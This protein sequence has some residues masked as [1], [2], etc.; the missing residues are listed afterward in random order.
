[1]TE[2]LKYNLNCYLRRDKKKYTLFWILPIFS[3]FLLLLCSFK[4]MAY[5]V[6][7]TN[8]E[9]LCEENCN[10]S[11]YYPYQEGFSY[12]FIKINGKKYE[13]EN[14]FFGNILLDSSNVGIQNITL[15]AKEYK[16]K[17]NEFVK[18]QI[19]KNKETLVNKI[20]KIM[21]ER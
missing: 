11:F 10:I 9:T 20:W 16:G 17:T 19:Y 21:K 6:Y 4:I 5:N 3:I 2:Y 18:L 13:V 14:I 1:M 12:D 15:I 8:A 7:E